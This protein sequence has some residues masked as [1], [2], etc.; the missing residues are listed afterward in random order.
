[1]TRSA[2]AWSKRAPGLNATSTSILAAAMAGNGATAT[3][4][5]GLAMAGNQ[6]SA[7][8]GS[9]AAAAASAKVPSKSAPGAGKSM[10]RGTGATGGN[11]ARL[12]G[13]A[14]HRAAGPSRGGR[15]ARRSAAK[16]ATQAAAAVVRWIACTALI[17]GARRWR[18][19]HGESRRQSLAEAGTTLS[20]NREAARGVAT[21]RRSNGAGAAGPEGQA[22]HCGPSPRGR[23]SCQSS[24]APPATWAGMGKLKSS[25]ITTRT[26]RRRSGSNIP[27]KLFGVLLALR[28][29]PFGFSGGGW[30][31]SRA[32]PGPAT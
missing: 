30:P 12:E 11:A 1:M 8:G 26:G 24:T 3:S 4:A 10:R 13:C 21:Q 7:V 18:S 5:L 17:V 23:R 20:A 25:T 31:S 9:M 6:E 32:T 22:A 14:H 29:R 2:R 15:N 27:G 19:K 28:R 16:W